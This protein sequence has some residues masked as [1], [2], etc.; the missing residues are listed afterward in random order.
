MINILKKTKP[1]DS[2]ERHSY[3]EKALLFIRD[4]VN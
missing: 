4:I 2:L 1:T 3:F